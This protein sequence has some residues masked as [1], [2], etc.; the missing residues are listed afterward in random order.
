MIKIYT[1]SHNR[2]D[3]I[4]HQYASMKKYIK[5]EFKFN[6]KYNKLKTKALNSVLNHYI[7]GEEQ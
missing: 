5:D 7:Y 6:D 2:P 1:Y 3:F 4:A